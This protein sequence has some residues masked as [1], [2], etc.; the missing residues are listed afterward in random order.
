[1]RRHARS[2]PLSDSDRKLLG[3]GLLAVGALAL[4]FA[5]YKTFVK[6]AA[7]S[8]GKVAGVGAT[9]FQLQPIR[10]IAPPPQ[11]IL[12]MGTTIAAPT[13][14]P[15]TGFTPQPIRGMTTPSP[16]STAGSMQAGTIPRLPTPAPVAVMGGS[17]PAGIPSFQQRGQ[18]PGLPTPPVAVQSGSAAAPSQPPIKVLT[19]SPTP[20]PQPPIATQGGT[21]S[22]PRQP[23][24]STQGG[25]APPQPPV[26]MQSGG[27]G[28]AQPPISMQSGGGGGGQPPIDV[29]G[30]GGGGGPVYPG[31]GDGGGFPTFGGG[32][33][34]GGAEESGDFSYNGPG[35]GGT[36]PN[37]CIPCGGSPPNIMAGAEWGGAS[38]G[39]APGSFD[40]GCLSGLPAQPTSIDSS[41]LDRT[42]RISNAPP[43]RV[44]VPLY[45][46]D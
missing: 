37:P 45:M 19:S 16:V 24:V 1:M 23:P 28:G 9:G 27:G 12:T 38:R 25:A 31:G 8:T 34:G 30:G 14:A 15:A 10:G 26:S 42:E 20:S 11:R 3:G 32:G 13:P 35:S 21:V 6:P 29:F 22:P 39:P 36:M 7:V 17:A 2:N 33:P 46:P 43:P 18:I 41:T 44:A 40:D 4:G 5:A